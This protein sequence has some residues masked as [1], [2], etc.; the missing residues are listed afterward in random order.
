MWVYENEASVYL[1][2][3][4]LESLCSHQ[5]AGLVTDWDTEGK[6]GENDTN[7]VFPSLKQIF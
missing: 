5:K 2:S 4:A 3:I 1:Y 6:F 7:T